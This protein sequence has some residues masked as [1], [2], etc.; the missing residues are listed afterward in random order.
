M[1]MRHDGD[2][3]LPVSLLQQESGPA[4]AP[5]AARAADAPVGTPAPDR[6]R[7]GP[8]GTQ[9]PELVA[10]GGPGLAGLSQAGIQGAESTID[11]KAVQPV[12]KAYRI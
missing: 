8:R 12:P 9:Q 10:P 6:S 1:H 4:T 3:E 7:P 5:T 2:F 11:V